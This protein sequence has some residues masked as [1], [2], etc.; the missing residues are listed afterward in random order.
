MSWLLKHWSG[1]T[2]KFVASAITAFL[3]GWSLAASAATNEAI[4]PGGGG[5][6]LVASGPVTVNSVQ[7]AL[8]NQPRDLTGVVMPDGSNVTSGQVIYFV[9]YVDNTTAYQADNVR[10]SDLLNESEFSYIPNSLETTVVASGSNDAVIWAGVWTPLTD[11]V[12]GPD[13]IASITDSGGP[14]GLDRITVGAE[15]GQ[16]NQSLTIPGNS[17]QAVRFRVTV[18]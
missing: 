7:L 13:D 10:I 4:D 18:N 2:T 12:G 3:L 17:L 14:A 15:T 1:L 16:I 9:L 6:S 8:V 11:A 5:V